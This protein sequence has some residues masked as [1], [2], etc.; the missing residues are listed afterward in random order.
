MSTMRR[1]PP[2]QV[3]RPGCRPCARWNWCAPKRGEARLQGESSSLTWN[4]DERL[5]VGEVARRRTPTCRRAA[6][7]GRG[8]APRRPRPRCAVRRAAPR[9]AGRY[10]SAPETAGGSRTRRPSRGR[11]MSETSITRRP[12]CQTAAHNSSPQRMRVV[13]AVAI[14]AARSASRRPRC[15]GPASTSAPPR[16]GRRRV[17]AGRRR[18]GCCRDSPPSRS[19]CRRSARPCR[20]GARRSRTSSGRRA[21][22]GRGLVRDVVDL[23]AAVPIAALARGLERRDVAGLDA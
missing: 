21:R 8:R 18:P 7:R 12:A 11:A 3:R 15:A 10:G 1:P 20:S 9:P 5:D 14:A 13:Q 19:R 6:G 22:V 16:L 17:G 4:I 2:N 23:E